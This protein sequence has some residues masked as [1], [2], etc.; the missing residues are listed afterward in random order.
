MGGRILQSSIN[1][2]SGLCMSRSSI[3][4]P[5]PGFSTEVRPFEFV[6]AVSDSWAGACVVC[7]CGGGGKTEH[8]KVLVCKTAAPYRHLRAAFA[9]PGSF[10]CLRAPLHQQHA[11]APAPNV[12]AGRTGATLLDRKRPEQEP[13]TCYTPSLM[14]GPAYPPSSLRK[15]LPRAA[16]ALLAVLL[17]PL[18]TSGDCSGPALLLV[19]E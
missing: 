2:T 17:Q 12:M 6:A 13:A 19:D 9:G 5:P 8:R 11:T 14:E 16:S 3:V 7:C 4:K 18:H 15:H 1:C 10:P